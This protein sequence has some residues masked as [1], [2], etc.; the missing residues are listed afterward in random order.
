MKDSIEHHYI[1]LT[2]TLGYLKIKLPQY[3]ID[4]VKVNVNKIQNN[5]SQSPSASNE[6]VGEINHEYY[7][8]LSTNTIN[9]I[10][11]AASKFSQYNPNPFLIHE[12]SIVSSPTPFINKY[13]GEAWINFQQKYEYNPVH[14]HSG[15]LSY[16]IWYQIPYLIEEEKKYSPNTTTTNGVF[17]FIYPYDN[18]INI[19]NLPIDKTM[20]GHMAIFPSVLA[21]TVYPFY[22]SEDYRITLSGNI[23]INP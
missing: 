13:K 17:Q 15:L 1:P 20:E 16:V 11:E 12:R 9:F 7:T 2:N 8:V 18:T 5:F 4:E 14:N 21:H 23:F 22:S 6:L 19:H 10:K 3:I